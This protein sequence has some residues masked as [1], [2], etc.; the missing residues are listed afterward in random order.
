MDWVGKLIHNFI[1]L[2]ILERALISS[3]LVPEGRCVQLGHESVIVSE[4]VFKRMQLCLNT[5]HRDKLCLVKFRC[6]EHGGYERRM[7]ELV[8]PE[9]YEIVTF[10]LTEY[11]EVK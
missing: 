5:A 8:Y 4:S 1:N 7:L 10:D 2:D 11:G 9:D 3:K 6:W